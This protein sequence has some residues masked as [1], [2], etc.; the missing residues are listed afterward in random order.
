MVS[1]ILIATIS[2]VHRR[3]SIVLPS[4]KFRLVSSPHVSDEETRALARSPNRMIH[5]EKSD[6]GTAETTRSV[7]RRSKQKQ[8]RLRENRTV[9][10]GNTMAHPTTLP[11]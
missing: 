2:P 10:V 4:L 11:L 7:A 9:P 8:R 6:E 1:F 5:I 3:Q